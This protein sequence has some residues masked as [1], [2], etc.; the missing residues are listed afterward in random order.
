M[1]VSEMMIEVSG[2]LL[3]TPGSLDEMQAHLEL[4]R[5]AWNMSLYSENKRKSKLKQFL[6]S[7]KPYAPSEE[8]L[9]G[10]E[11]EF[12]RIIKQKN[13]LFPEVKSKIEYAQAI[14][15]SKDNYIIR[16]YFSDPYESE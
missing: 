15:T 6:Q 4:V 14:E 8:D 16:A 11:W 12:R 3:E 1:K 9:K 10:L 5:Q 13:V 7:Q 2:E